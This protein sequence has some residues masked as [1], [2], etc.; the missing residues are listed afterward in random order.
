[1]WIWMG[2]F[3]STASLTETHLGPSSGD[4]RVISADAA[5]N[6]ESSVA[7]RGWYDPSWSSV[8]DDD[9]DDDDDDDEHFDLEEKSLGLRCSDVMAD[10]AT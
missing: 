4:D 9:D 7:D 3:I 6:I 5:W 10:V 1:M 2:N 8:T